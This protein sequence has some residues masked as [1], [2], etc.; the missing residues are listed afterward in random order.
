MKILL[1][2][3]A[4]RESL[5]SNKERYFIKAGSRWPWS[6]IKPKN[7]KNSA[8]IFPF[9]LAYTASVLKN[10]GHEVSVI[11]GVA[12][13]LQEDDFLDRLAGIDPDLV[14]IETAT[15]S[16]RHDISFA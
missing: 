15:H 10:E 4:T 3:P 8:C 13:D 1:A 14:L 2:N 6:Y 11:D 5:G 16:I 9:F 7:K 12:M